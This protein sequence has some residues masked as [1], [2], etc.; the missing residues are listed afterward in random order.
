MTGPRKERL[1]VVDNEPIHLSVL[2]EILKADYDIL[3]ATR[4]EDALVSAGAYRPDMILLDIEMGGM[5]GH[6]VCRRLRADPKTQSIPIVFLTAKDAIDD[7]ARGLELGAV[8]YITKPISPPIV[9]ARVRTQLDLK[10]QRDELIELTEEKNRFLAIAAHDLRSLVSSIILGTQGVMNRTKDL[11]PERD[12][13]TLERVVRA[14]R[15]MLSLLEGLLDAK[16]IERGDLVMALEPGSLAEIVLERLEFLKPLSD[17]KNLTVLP[18]LQDV[19]AFKLDRERICQTFD[20]V[21]T[22]AIKYSPKN[23][24]IRVRLVNEGDWARVEVQ[25]EGEG[26]DQ[27]QAAKAFGEFETLGSKP[28]AGESSLGLGLF[29]VKRI[30]EAH[31]GR[32]AL[33][34]APGKGSILTFALPIRNQ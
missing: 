30:V 26:V 33:T 10:R 4:G 11:V 21:F 34:G 20:N 25:D 28:T 5:D 31:G 3:I 8:D 13:G 24:T 14:S 2:C 32:V 12:R 1:L 27:A 9:R 6:E 15:Q 22:N 29:I 17:L 23:T 7:E 18:E 19:P 16:R